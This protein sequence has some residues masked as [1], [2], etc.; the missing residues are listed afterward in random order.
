M[1]KLLYTL[2]W[3]TIFAA[4][5]LMGLLIYW[6]LFPKLPIQ[7]YQQP[8]KVLTKQVKS[9]DYL[10]YEAWF[11]K[12]SDIT[13]EVSKAFIDGVIYEIPVVV[14]EAYKQGCGMAHIQVYIPRNLPLGTY[15][16]QT[17]YRY[18]VNPVKVFDITTKTEAFIVK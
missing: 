11:C 2:S 13:P 10:T 17:N 3:T 14:F 8:H 1:N 7:F 4:M 16:I 6:Y 15:Y 12:Y 18:Q 5:G 9:G